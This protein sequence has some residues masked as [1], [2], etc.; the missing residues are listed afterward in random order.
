MVAFFFSVCD[1]MMSVPGKWHLT[2]ALPQRTADLSTLQ[3]PPLHGER[4]HDEGR[5]R[6]DQY[7]CALD[8][9]LSSPRYEP[10]GRAAL[11]KCRFSQ[12]PEPEEGIARFSYAPD[13]DRCLQPQ[14]ALSNEGYQVLVVDYKDSAT[15]QHAVMGVD[16]VISTVTGIPQLNL[17]TAASAQRVRRFAPAEFEGPPRK[18]RA[19]DPLKRGEYKK[20]IRDWLKHFVENERSIQEYTF[21]ICGVLYERFGPGGLRSHRL[22]S[23]CHRDGEGDFAINARTMQSHAPIYDREQQPVSICLTAAED[24]ARFV[25]R[26]LDLSRWPREMT[27]VGERM[28]VW[29]LVNVVKGVRG[30]ARLVN[31]FKCRGKLT[32]FSGTLTEDIQHTHAS[33]QYAV[34]LAQTQGDVAAIMRALD[35]LA[36]AEGAYDFAAPGTLNASPRCR[37]ITPIRFED[38]LQRVW[39]QPGP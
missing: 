6:W 16:T 15:L 37:D 8:S 33:L 9:P 28:T 7:S 12:S 31:G 18:Q 1:H 11:P 22:A 36:A 20:T 25:V 3:Q 21:F 39:A 10:P 5:R 34:Q 24:V 23:Q 2:T 29:E 19:D 13:A 38:W 27:M 17:L 14:P 32:T 30:A 26:A 4:Q 35:L